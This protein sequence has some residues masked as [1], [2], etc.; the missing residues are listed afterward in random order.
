MV[1]GEGGDKGSGGENT[2]TPVMTCTPSETSLTVF[3]LEDKEVSLY[4]L[5]DGEVGVPP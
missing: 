4:L 1:V 5:L 3:Y 2:G